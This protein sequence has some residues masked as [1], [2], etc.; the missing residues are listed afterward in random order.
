MWLMFN[1]MADDVPS[2]PLTL[3]LQNL[4]VFHELCLY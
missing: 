1:K 4:M 2:E 3:D